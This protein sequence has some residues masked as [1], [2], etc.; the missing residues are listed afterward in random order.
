MSK[1]VIGLFT[2][3]IAFTSLGVYAEGEDD[4]DSVPEGLCMPFEEDMGLCSRYP[5]PK[6]KQEMIR[7]P[8]ERFPNL[9]FKEIAANE[10]DS[11]GRVLLRHNELGDGGNSYIVNCEVERDN[12][13]RFLVEELFYE[14]GGDLDST[15]SLGNGELFE[16]GGY[17]VDARM[18]MYKNAIPPLTEECTPNRMNVS[19][20]IHYGNEEIDN[21]NFFAKQKSYP[22][23]ILLAEGNSDVYKPD[24]SFF[25]GVEYIGSMFVIDEHYNISRIDTM[26][27]ANPIN[28]GQN[29]DIHIGAGEKLNYVHILE[30]Y[31]GPVNYLAIDVD[32]GE[33][34]FTLKGMN[35]ITHVGDMFFELNLS[36]LNESG[37]FNDL[38]SVN[39]ITVTD[40]SSADSINI[41]NFLED[42]SITGSLNLKGFGGSSGGL[43]EYSSFSN[44]TYLPEVLSLVDINSSVN[45]LN[46]VTSVGTLIIESVDG[47]INGLQGLREIQGS[48]SIESTSLTNVNFLRN[49][50]RI[51]NLPLYRFRHKFRV[52]VF[53]GWNDNLTDISGLE[54]ISYTSNPIYIEDRNYQVK[55]DTSSD[56]CQAVLSGSVKIADPSY[57]PTMEFYNP[58]ALSANDA[59]NFICN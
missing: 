21:Y 52:G 29:F 12:Y 39:N 11:S 55:P 30:K 35:K 20:I 2:I 54:N 34:D 15:I 10:D 49:I 5:E 28:I 50:E 13:Y 6:Y 32:S 26:N 43:T 31:T 57:T 40:Y 14:D 27:N 22:D 42:I 51:N 24:L 53:I 47:E 37:F 23:G 1:V 45:G 4:F 18:R 58:P 7:V 48:L 41:P 16:L 17:S 8:S 3:S 19:G 44:V 33:Q 46:N 59:Y 25:D 9:P 56:F 38:S 36:K